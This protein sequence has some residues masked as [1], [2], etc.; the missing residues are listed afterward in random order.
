MDRCYS[1]FCEFEEAYV[2][3]PNC[4][5]VYD[6]KP[7][8][9]N[10]LFPGTVLAGRYIIGKSVGV[11]GFGIVYKAW[12][13]KLEIIIA[14]KEFFV[15][16]L[17]TRAVGVKEPIVS[18]KKR[19]EWV[20]HKKRFL[21]EART[22]A[23]FGMHKS[24]PNVFEVFEENNTA[25]I[26]MELLE[27]IRLDKYLEQLEGKLDLDFS[28][29]I[30][31][32]VGKA[33]ESM[34]KLGVIHRDVAPD[35][36][37]ICSGSEISIKLM[38]LGAAR[39]NSF[40][41]DE[42]LVILKPGYSPPEQY[43]PSGKIGTWSDVYSLG[44][45]LYQ[46]LTGVKPTEST[47]RKENDD[48]PQV[49]EINP[50]ITT[51]VNNTVMKAI[52][53][54]RHMRFKT[55]PDFL[56][57]INGEEKVET[58]AQE[59]KRRKL[60]RFYGVVAASVI[61]AVISLLVAESFRQKHHEQVLDEASISVWF[62]VQDDSSEEDAMK[63]VFDDFVER[64]SGIEINY[65]AIPASEYLSVLEEAAK[66]DSL[67]NLFESTGVSD[68]I[69]SKALDLDAIFK[70]EQVAE[71]LFLDQYNSYYETLKQIPLAIDVPLAYVI[72]GGATQIEYAEDYFSS[73]EDFGDDTVISCDTRY[74]NLIDINFSGKEFAKQ[75]D[76]LTPTDNLSPVLLSSS[77]IINEV[78]ELPYAKKYVYYKSDDIKCEFTY[79]WSI[80]NGTENEVRA[81]EVLLSWMLGNVYQRYL[82][83][84]S[85]SN[86]QVPEIPVNRECF[87]TKINL[88]SNLKPISQIYMNFSFERKD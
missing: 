39:L 59:K 5:E 65:K 26:V 77:M 58:L 81:S 73:I 24:I 23:K 76:F 28:V 83:V 16:N 66:T 32:E 33:L 70:S 54:D 43:E 79:E 30:T 88:L 42:L 13:T 20:C 80:G 18:K 67:P 53:I 44:A 48:L 69:L 72:T 60:K 12:D 8:E 63:S 68:T 7:N 75:E 19:D 9:A 61:L 21:D 55:I 22:M 52:A 34:H 86:G 87:E 10:H 37:F 4:G 62:S 35:N 71:C 45:T 36:I 74:R 29:F 1:C 84:N 51:N 49:N 56:K 3:C 50:Q 14:V 38:D 64:F 17:M 46:L 31:N 78:R 15:S 41:D 47:N 2:V 25:Y 6:N 85:G 11:G 57:A 27:G 82:M 40:P